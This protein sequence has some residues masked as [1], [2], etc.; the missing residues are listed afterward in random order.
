[1]AHFYINEILPGSYWGTGGP[2]LADFDHDGDLDAALSRRVT[3]GAS[4][5]ERVNDSI[6]TPHVIGTSQNLAKT[7][8]TAAIDINRDGWMDVVFEGVWFRNP[9]TLEKNHDAQWT[10][11]NF[12]GGGH[13]AISYDINR[14]SSDEL[15]IYDGYKLA[16]YTNTYEGLREH[17][18]DYGYEDHGGIAPK[19]IGDLDGDSDPDIIIPGFWFENT[20]AEGKWIRHEWPFQPVPNA[21]YGR[22]IR[23]WIADINNDGINDIIYSN[24][25]TGGGHVFWV[26]NKDNGTNWVSHELPDP[27]TRKGDVPGTGSFHSLGVAD[28]N[29]DGNPDIFAGEQEDP[30]TY[31]EGGGK[32]AMKPR[33][34]KE[35]GVIWYNKGGKNPA[36]E[37]FL[38]HVGNPGWHDAQIGDVTATGI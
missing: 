7:L 23:S 12:K 15:I 19:G 33:G 6:W 32:V 4:W 8:G 3:E 10:A 13:D 2:A 30:D 34:L 24:C 9:G 21:S 29:Q 1:M 37:I 5:Y 31:M 20:G 11:I 18:I 25:D 16:W 38:I 28:F 26:E 27:P 22:S 35:R 36:F 14:D 17:I